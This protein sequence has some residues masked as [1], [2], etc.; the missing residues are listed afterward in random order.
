MVLACT[1]AAG[2]VLPPFVCFDRKSLNIKLTEGEVPGTE[3]Y[4]S[5][6]VYN[7]G[8]E[9]VFNELV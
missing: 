1:S 4:S 5:V 2:Y 7:D 8:Y 9:S 3:L 6:M